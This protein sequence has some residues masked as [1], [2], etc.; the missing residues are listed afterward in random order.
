MPSNGLDSSSLD[1][2]ALLVGRCCSRAT[3]TAVMLRAEGYRVPGPVVTQPFY[4]CFIAALQACPGVQ[5]VRMIEEDMSCGVPAA[6]ILSSSAS[7]P[8]VTGSSRLSSELEASELVAVVIAIG[9]V[10]SVPVGR[11]HSRGADGGA[12]RWPTSEGTERRRIRSTSRTL[13]VSYTNT[14][15]HQFDHRAPPP[16]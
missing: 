14:T 6:H 13:Y 16:G 15:S 7:F 2:L 8:H 9:K 3:S 10:E 1:K 5:P 12:G 11:R 4:S